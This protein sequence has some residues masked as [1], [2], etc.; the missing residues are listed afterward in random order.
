MINLKY[1]ILVANRKKHSSI[2]GELFNK[3]TEYI[4]NGGVYQWR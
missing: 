1:T 4:Q 2:L 3:E